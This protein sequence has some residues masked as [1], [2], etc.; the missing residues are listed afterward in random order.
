MLTHHTGGTGAVVTLHVALAEAQRSGIGR[1]LQRARVQRD[2]TRREWLPRILERLGVPPPAG[3]LAALRYWE[4]TGERPEQ[5]VAAA[6]PVYLEAGMNHLHLHALPAALSP[7]AD[8]RAAFESLATQLDAAGTG[9][10]FLA[11][12]GTGYL[13]AEAPLAT[14][15]LSPALA[16]G[17]APERWLPAPG[18]APAHARLLAEVQMCLHDADVNRRRAAAGAPPLNALWLW[19]GGRAPG[20]SPRELPLLVG[21]DPVVRGYWKSASAR[22]ARWPGSLAAARALGAGAGDSFVAV[23]PAED[24]AGVLAELAEMLQGGAP[25]RLTLLFAD[26]ASAELRRADRLR[27]WRRSTC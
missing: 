21:D 18:T 14:A 4:Q 8:V 19:G 2:G 17:A 5:W 23:P 13:L 27:F 12:E 22:A 6:D 16:Q 24:P 20:P 3:G 9:G 7:P 26:G 1:W 10:R 25:G 15:E 11:V